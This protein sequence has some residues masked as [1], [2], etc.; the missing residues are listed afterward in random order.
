MSGKSELAMGGLLRVAQLVAEEMDRDAPLLQVM[1]FLR[2]ASAGE[3]GVD[4][5]QLLNELK[6]S[7]ASMSRTTQALSAVHYQKDRE[8]F[9]LVEI[10]FDAQDKR[11][12][13]VRLTPKGEKLAAKLAAA[14][15][16]M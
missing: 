3:A 16:R 1:A 8:G 6:A 10:T 9:G 5:G 13:I 7:S 11:R 15:S 2:I 12:R 14:M 4:S